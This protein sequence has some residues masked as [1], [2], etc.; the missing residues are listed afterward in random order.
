MTATDYK[1]RRAIVDDVPQLVELLKATCLPAETLEKR[2]TEFQVVETGEGVLIGAIGLQIIG[3]H[4]ELHSETYQDFSLAD[5]LRPLLWGRLQHVAQNH[6]LVRL[7]TRETAPFW[8]QNGFETP[9]EAALEKFPEPLGEPDSKWLTLKLKE[10][11]ETILS[12]EKEFAMFMEAEKNRTQQ[13]F[14]HA[15][16]LKLVSYGLAAVLLLFVIIS[17]ILLLR[18]TIR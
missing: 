6:G 16:T 13:M 15:R 2:F 3:K 5:S 17:S 9:D 10:E 11:L 1:V 7:W 12:L 14:D 8:K 4:G 18:Q